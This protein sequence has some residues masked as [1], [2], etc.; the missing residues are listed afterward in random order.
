MPSCKGAVFEAATDVLSR[1]KQ[2][3][4]GWPVSPTAGEEELSAVYRRKAVVVVGGDPQGAAKAAG[5]IDGNC[6]GLP[7]VRCCTRATSAS[8]TAA[9]RRLAMRHCSRAA[10]WQ[11]HGTNSR[12]LHV[13]ALQ[14]D[15]RLPQGLCALKPNE[16]FVNP[17]SA[18]LPTVSFPATPPFA[19]RL[20]GWNLAPAATELL[21]KDPR[22]LTRRLK[23]LLDDFA[24]W[25]AR[26][27]LACRSARFASPAVS[28]MRTC[29]ALRSWRRCGRVRNN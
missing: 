23:S 4:A 17:L 29:A 19:R 6:H 18:G 14:G 26:A 8:S 9:T 5:R 3:L 2:S 28:C 25:R 13:R 22:Q 12:R 21:A 24:A 11:S 16:R 7:H 10:R 20:R 15:D 27:S 1:E